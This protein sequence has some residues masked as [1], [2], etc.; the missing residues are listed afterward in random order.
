M[1]TQ[2]IISGQI[3]GNHKLRSAIITA[4]CKE[5]SGMFNSFILTFPTKKS[6]I[7]ALSN[8]YQ[9]MCAEMPDEKNKIS[10]INYMRGHSLSYDASKA[11]IQ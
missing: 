2:I 4:E 8:A 10:G 7:K 1:K 6:A 5:K 9:S 3:N 11:V